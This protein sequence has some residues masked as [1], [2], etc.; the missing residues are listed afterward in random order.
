MS[1]RATCETGRDGKGL[2]SMSE[3]V[4]ASRSSCQ[5]GKVARRRKVTKARMMATMLR[6]LLA[7]CIACW[8][9][10][11]CLQEVGE[12]DGVLERCSDPDQIQRILVDVDALRK[13]GGVV[14]AQESSICVCAE[15]KVSNTNFERC[16]SDDVGNGCCDAW[17]DLSGVV[18]GRVVIVVEVDEE[19]AGDEWRG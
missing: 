11:G 9:A 5:P 2:M 13:S 6:E 14:R 7:G 15:S 4:R 18:I 1:A 16:L 3:P 10:N 17:I 19:D 8:W 12:D